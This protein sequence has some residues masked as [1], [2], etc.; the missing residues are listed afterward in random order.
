MIV[1]ISEPIDANELTFNVTPLLSELNW[2]DAITGDEHDMLY[3]DQIEILKFVMANLDD[4]KFKISQDKKSALDQ[5]E[6]DFQEKRNRFYI[7]YLTENIQNTKLYSWL[8]SCQI[9]DFRFYIYLEKIS[10]KGPLVH[11]VFNSKKDAMM[12]KLTWIGVYEILGT[13]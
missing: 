7:R 13:N 2:D 4:H 6:N 1:A 12:F 5:K 9:R 10:Y 3:D 8:I 11:V